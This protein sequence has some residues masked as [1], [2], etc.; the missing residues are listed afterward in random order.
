ME[1]QT[2]DDVTCTLAS[3]SHQAHDVHLLLLARG[4]VASIPQFMDS[5]DGHTLKVT[6]T[7]SKNLI[8]LNILENERDHIYASHLAIVKPELL[9]NQQFSESILLCDRAQDWAADSTERCYKRGD[10]QIRL[11][12]KEQPIISCELLVNDQTHLSTKGLFSARQT[13]N[14]K[15][16]AMVARLHN[17]N[18]PHDVSDV[19]AIAMVVKQANGSLIALYMFLAGHLEQLVQKEAKTWIISTVRLKNDELYETITEEC[20]T[21]LSS[22]EKSEKLDEKVGLWQKE[23]LL[24]TITTSVPGYDCDGIE[25]LQTL[26][27]SFIQDFQQNRSVSR[28]LYIFRHPEDR[29]VL[30]KVY[31]PCS[32]GEGRFVPG[33]ERR[34][35]SVNLQP[36]RRN[37]LETSGR[38]PNS[39]NERRINRTTGPSG[40]DWSYRPG[41]HERMHRVQTDPRRQQPINRP[42]PATGY[43]FANSARNVGPQQH[44]THG[45]YG[46]HGRQDR[47]D[48]WAQGH[49]RPRHSSG[50]Y[51]PHGGGA[52]R[53]PHSRVESCR[54][55]GRVHRNSERRQ[56]RPQSGRDGGCY[57]QSR[58]SEE[59]RGQQNQQQHGGAGM[60]S[61]RY[62]E[63]SPRYS[64]RND[65]PKPG[66]YAN[67]SSK[68][69]KSGANSN[70]V[71]TATVHALFV[72]ES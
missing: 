49:S 4:Y 14:D 26:P 37:E 40:S 7:H 20:F 51:G 56:H 33:D 45:Y 34:S 42:P 38:L 5:M 69:T 17:L 11:Y 58:Q 3:Y 44:S 41:P 62:A 21:T 71:S 64:H 2:S 72:I 25:N 13:C 54:H 28:R 48:S 65:F 43:S 9:L 47:R 30:I 50:T 6:T 18:E 57:R 52:S 32:P 27:A 61:G 66:E 22:H 29:T 67:K 31:E 10:L 8:L 12:G 63:R 1:A 36:S 46:G 70:A 60:P 59:I 24:F 55:Y 53:Y 15:L 16:S 23:S 19:T 68:R 35:V 39:Q